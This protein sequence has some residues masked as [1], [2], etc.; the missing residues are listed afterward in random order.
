MSFQ[1][2]SKDVVVV[3][4]GLVVVAGVVLIVV[5]VLKLYKEPARAVAYPK[6]LT[7]YCINLP[8]DSVR[9]KHMVDVFS[10]MDIGIEF[11]EAVDTRGD[12]WKEYTRYL[13][14]E[15]RRQLERTLNNQRRREHYE[16]TPGAI[17]CF[18]SHVRCWEVF[19]A[20]P[21]RAEED[22][23]LVLEDDSS[24]KPWFTD[25]LNKSV[26][27]MP[28]DT[29]MFLLNSITFGDKTRISSSDFS[30]YRLE[31]HS[32]FYLMNA[33][34]ITVPGIVRVLATFESSGMRFE[35]QID[36]YLSDMIRRGALRVCCLEENVCP[37]AAVSPTAIQT[38]PV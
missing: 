25:V 28:A 29:D 8:D 15:G 31:Q 26:L 24:P 21:G 17:G 18:L 27:Y 4:A 2:S 35:K 5:F 37:Q 22:L 10:P 14:E 36:S 12:R 38:L 19:L 11:I 6:R 13:T 7:A 34:I 33:Y 1:F 20:S 32:I 30:F 3:V 23:L 9:R 16:L